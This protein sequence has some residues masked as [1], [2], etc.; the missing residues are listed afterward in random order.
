MTR[1]GMT[2]YDAGIASSY[3]MADILDFHCVG[4]SANTM[5]N[6]IKIKKKSSKPDL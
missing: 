1:D 3:Q 5:S 4:K 6:L 2:S